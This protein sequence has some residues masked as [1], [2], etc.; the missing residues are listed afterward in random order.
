MTPPKMPTLKGRS[1]EYQIGDY[2]LHVTFEEEDR[3]HWTYVDAPE[4]EKGKNAHEKLDVMVPLR[5]NLILLEWKEAS[6]TQIIDVWDLQNMRLHVSYVT[7]DGERFYAEAD[8]KP[9]K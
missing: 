9:V 1:F 2:H 4:G 5:D 6:N 8:L 3:L 7:S